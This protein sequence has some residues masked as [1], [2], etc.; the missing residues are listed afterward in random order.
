MKSWSD[1]GMSIP[2]SVGQNEMPPKLWSKWRPKGRVIIKQCC[3]LFS[4]TR[5]KLLATEV[6]DLQYTLKWIQDKSQDEAHCSLGKL[7]KLALRELRISKRK[8]YEPNLLHLPIFRKAHMHACMHAHFSSV[9]VRDPMDCSLL[10]S[11]VHGILQ[12]RILGWLSSFAN[13]TYRRDYLFST[14]YFCFLCWI[15]IIRSLTVSFIDS[16]CLLWCLCKKASSSRRFIERTFWQVCSNKF[17]II[18]LN[19]VRN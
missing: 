5:I 8:F 6:T 17:Q 14:A 3:P 1:L 12:A 15:I 10:G 9:Q 4:S 16:Y 2:S 18:P 11:S 19:W 13:T 7:A